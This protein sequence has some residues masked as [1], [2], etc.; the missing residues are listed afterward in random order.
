[1]KKL[2]FFWLFMII[3]NLLSAQSFQFPKKIGSITTKI[4]GT[5]LMI[6]QGEVSVS[7]WFAFIYAQYFDEKQNKLLEGFEKML[8]DTNCMPKK[9]RFM[10]NV[11]LRLQSMENQNIDALYVYVSDNSNVKFYIPLSVLEAKG[12]VGIKLFRFMQLPIV[13]VTYE[14]VQNYLLWRT[15]LANLDKHIVKTGFKVKARLMKKE[16]WDSL[17]LNIGPRLPENKSKQI[18]SIN[19][20]GCYLLNVKIENPCNQ[21]VENRKIFDDGAFPIYSYAPDKTGLY[22]I[23]GNVSEMTEEKGIAKGGSY[24]DYAADCN[25]NKIINYSQAQPWLGF[26]CVLEFYK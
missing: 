1:M 24:L 15:E 17:S 26:R 11:F 18:D 25:A 7:D 3:N 19:T 22:C 20:D 12:D 2:I 4:E 9:Y 23:Y 6:D 14:Q 10:V 5:Q 21:L 8:P 13:G 16:E